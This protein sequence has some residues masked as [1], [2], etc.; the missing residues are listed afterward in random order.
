MTSGIIIEV[1][2]SKEV[3]KDN[4]SYEGRQAWKIKNYYLF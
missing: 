1:D 2:E 3:G 4:S